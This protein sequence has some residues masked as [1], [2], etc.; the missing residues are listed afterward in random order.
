[1]ATKTRSINR[2][3]DGSPSDT[4]NRVWV[5]T[6]ATEHSTLADICFDADPYRLALIMTGAGVNLV[7]DEHWTFY[8]NERSA[9]AEATRR[10]EAR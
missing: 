9:T 6:D 2:N 3:A 4:T 8:T 7:R 1:M 10:L 5:V